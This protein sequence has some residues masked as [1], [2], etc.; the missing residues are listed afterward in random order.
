M[1]R[2][3]QLNL[4]RELTIAHHKLRDQSTF[5]GFLWSFLHPLVLLLVFYGFF[6][7]MGG[8]EVEHYAAYIL[9]G[10]VFYNHFSNSTKAALRSL[11]SMRHLTAETVFPKELIVA[12]WTVSSGIDFLI[13]LAIA[14]LLALLSGVPLN[15]AWL[16][17][18]VLVVAQI[19]LALWVGLLLAC[20]YLV[21]WDLDHI[22]EIF[23]RLLF[24]ITPIFYTKDLLGSGPAQLVVK[25]NPLARMIDFARGVVIEGHG[26]SGA[27]LA[28]LVVINAAGLFAAYRIFKKLEPAFAEN[29]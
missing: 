21:A 4:L 10:L 19:V 29:A 18:P 8:R 27:A 25:F 11:R 28:A 6:R 13:S 24:F 5:F 1:D 7:R 14:L 22:Y 17:L 15:I 3:A 23:L 20:M 9:I 16:W 26:L 12:S 2:R